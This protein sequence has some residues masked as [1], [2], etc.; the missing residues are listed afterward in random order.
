MFVCKLKDN[1]LLKSDNPDVDIKG[2]NLYKEHLMSLEPKLK[3]RSSVV[4]L[5]IKSTDKV[6]SILV[7]T[8]VYSPE[9]DINYHLNNLFIDVNNNNSMD[10]D[11]NGNSTSCENLNVNKKSFY[12]NSNN[13][14]T[15]SMARRR[16]SREGSV[17]S[18]ASASEKSQIREALSRKNSFIQYFE[19]KY[20]TPD[21]CVDTLMDAVD[22]IIK[23]KVL[24]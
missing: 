15:S 24:A 1:F 23:D 18:F 5:D 14:S 17:G 4:N 3:R 7:C 16:M 13:S 22:Y 20:N 10:L 9:S 12:L 2:A 11:E 21:L 6:E 19:G 8:G